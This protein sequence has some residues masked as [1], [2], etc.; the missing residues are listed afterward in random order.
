VKEDGTPI[1]VDA[2]LVRYLFLFLAPLGFLGLV[3]L[4]MIATSE[5]KQ[6]LGDKAAGTIVVR[7]P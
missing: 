1:D 7:F 6:R 5:K 3:T 2:A 4:V